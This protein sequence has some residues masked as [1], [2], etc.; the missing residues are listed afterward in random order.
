MIRDYSYTGGKSGVKKDYQVKNFNNPYFHPEKKSLTKHF[1]TKLY[2][3]IL[4]ALFLLYVIIYSDLFKITA[5][6]VTGTDLIDQNEIRAMTEK[7]LS[8][9]KLFLFPKRNMIFF[10]K[11]KLEQEIGGRYALNKLE[12]KKSWHR[13]DINLEEKVAY[14]IATNNQTSYFVDMTGTIIKELSPQEM[15]DYSPRFPKLVLTQEIKIGDQPISGRFVNYVL[16]LDKD[17]KIHNIKV[18]DYQS[19]GVDQ[20]FMNTEAGWQAKFSINTNI[21]FSLEN[22]YFFL[23]K[24][25]KGKTF[26]YIDLRIGDHVYVF[27]EQGI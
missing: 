6:G 11:N 12:I 7:E 27:P 22:L 20:V 25:L 19:G 18:K 8:G 24:K 14:L 4:L 1:N 26:Q 3:Q 17:L 9:C 5:V 10:N 15:I 13:L 23:D 2:L 16:E 21:K